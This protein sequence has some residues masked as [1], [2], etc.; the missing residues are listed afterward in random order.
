[1]LEDESFPVSPGHLCDKCYTTYYA[2]RKEEDMPR[3]RCRIPDLGA[4]VAEEPEEAEEPEVT[5]EIEAEN[6]DE[7]MDNSMNH[8]IFEED[9]E[10]EEEDDSSSS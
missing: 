4:S 8:S 5:E 2:K 10:E 6:A 7:T 3:F 1:M 9:T